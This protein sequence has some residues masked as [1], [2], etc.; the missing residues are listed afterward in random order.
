M[1]TNYEPY[2]EAEFARKF[3]VALPPVDFKRE[4]YPGYIAPVVRNIVRRNDETPAGLECIPARFGLVPTWAK[5]EDVERPTLKFATYNARVETIGQLPS[6]KH[7]WRNRRF[8]LIPVQSFYEPCWETG[9]AVRWKMALASGEPF[10][11]AG[12]WERWQRDDK[13]VDSFT[14]LTVNAD[15]HAVMKRMHRPGDEKRMPVLLPAED[16]AHWLDATPELALKLCQQYPA[17][18]MTAVA[19]PAPK[20]VS[21]KA[22]T[23][24]NQAKMI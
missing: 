21:A 20:R 22:A 18:R 17:E 5:P 19:T 15:D 14:M 23:P 7:A 16:W 4:T 12:L 3:G 11:L 24:S 9:R 8:C 13:I 1:C 2:L 6:F 10:A